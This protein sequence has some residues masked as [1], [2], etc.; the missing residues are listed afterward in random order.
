MLKLPGMWSAP[1][2]IVENHSLPLRH[3]VLPNMDVFSSS[4]TYIQ[5]LE[6]NGSVA[7]QSRNLG[8]QIMPLSEDTLR[9]AGAKTFT[10]R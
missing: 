8:G 2:R 9:Q 3:V 6:R 7:V 1:P 5:V 4:N 10:K